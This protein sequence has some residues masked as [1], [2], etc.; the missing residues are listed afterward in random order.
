MIQY[1]I[2]NPLEAA[3]RE[4]FFDRNTNKLSYK[5]DLGII[6]PFAPT[7]NTGGLPAWLE[8]NATDLT[9]WNNGQGNIA[10]NT[11]FGDGAL[12]RKR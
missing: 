4:V 6:V 2:K 7:T 9:I 5:D 10:T 3:R 8:S 11:S 1:D 12:K